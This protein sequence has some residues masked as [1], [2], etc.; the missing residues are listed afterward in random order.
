V[1][2]LV[3][4]Y[5]DGRLASPL[6]SELEEHVA[7]CA[8]CR[9]TLALARGI[10]VALSSAAPIKAPIGFANRVMAQVYRQVPGGPS[11][12][13][14]ASRTT[15]AEAGKAAAAR[16][17]R[18]LG[19]SFM[20]TAAVLAASLLVPRAAYPGLLGSLGAEIAQGSTSLVQTVM[21]GAGDTARGALGESDRGGNTR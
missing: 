13:A 9:K 18:R 12:S 15:R 6:A 10:G 17:Y 5:V 7:G 11:V 1:N 2:R 21:T 4:T 14:E 20:L 19:L 8:R 16:T 3:D